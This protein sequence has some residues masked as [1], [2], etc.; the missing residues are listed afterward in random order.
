MLLCCLYF[1]QLNVNS[2]RRHLDPE[3]VIRKPVFEPIEAYNYREESRT[4]EDLEKIKN[5]ADELHM[6]SLTVRLVPGSL[7]LP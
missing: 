5:N 6:E 7:K 1:S 4:L 3:N 2:T